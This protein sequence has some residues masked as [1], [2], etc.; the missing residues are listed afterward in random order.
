MKIEEEERYANCSNRYDPW[1]GQRGGEGR[2]R[3]SRE[4]LIDVGNVG[5]KPHT[6]IIRS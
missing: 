6:L 3:V 2:G 4:K 5:L 1:G